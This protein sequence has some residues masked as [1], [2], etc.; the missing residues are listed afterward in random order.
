MSSSTDRPLTPH[1]IT[2]T[3]LVG[4]KI[5]KTNEPLTKHIPDSTVIEEPPQKISH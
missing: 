4:R 5:I 3:V 2:E 1:P